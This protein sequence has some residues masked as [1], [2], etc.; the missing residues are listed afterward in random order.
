MFFHDTSL[1][2]S[3]MP[4]DARNCHAHSDFAEI[5]NLVYNCPAGCFPLKSKRNEQ[6]SP[7]EQEECPAG[8]AQ[9]LSVD[10]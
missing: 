1:H 7:K 9:S 6:I 10:L 3:G 2:H 4:K 8:V 5:R